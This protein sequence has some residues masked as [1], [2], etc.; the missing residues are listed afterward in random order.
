MR[1]R[2]L[3]SML[4]GVSGKTLINDVLNPYIVEVTAIIN[5]RPLVS[6]STDPDFPLTPPPPQAMLLTQ[7]TEY[8]CEAHSSGEIHDRGVRD[9]W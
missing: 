2:I 1:G 6:V 4:I 9:N 5:S 7:K 8:K 3:D